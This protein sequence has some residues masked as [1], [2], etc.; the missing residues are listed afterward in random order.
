[1]KKLVLLLLIIIAF[2]PKGHSQINSEITLFFSPE[3]SKFDRIY[4]SFGATHDF[5]PGFHYGAELGFFLSKKFK[6][7]LGFGYALQENAVK[8]EGGR[9]KILLSDYRVIPLTLEYYFLSKKKIEL[10]GGV[11]MQIRKKHMEFFILDPYGHPAAPHLEKKSYQ[12]LLKAG[13][14]YFIHRHVFL[15][16]AF[17]AGLPIFK[18][19]ASN[20][21]LIGIQLG[22]G[23]NFEV[24]NP[25]K[26]FLY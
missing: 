24:P 12:V 16:A 6:L 4:Y 18:R 17:Q 15:K 22:L 14:K 19:P 1:M 5:D 13:G 26:K 10:F 23:V 3:F 21:T 7:S 20:V 2:T 9:N 11:G 25:I 8:Y